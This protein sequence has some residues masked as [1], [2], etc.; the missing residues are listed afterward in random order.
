M[1]H[2]IRLREK[3]SVR[4]EPAGWQW[5]RSMHCPTNLE[6]TDDVRLYWESA[7]QASVQSLHINGRRVGFCAER[8]CSDNLVDILQSFN[9]VSLTLDTFPAAAVAEH[10]GATREVIL[11][12]PQS[13]TLIDAWLLIT[14]IDFTTDAGTAAQSGS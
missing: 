9:K 8:C 2:R 12:D 1:T 11:P 6:A 14:P 13:P 5:T 4:Q 10:V 3:W 7:S